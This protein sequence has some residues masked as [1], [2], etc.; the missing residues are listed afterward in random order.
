MGQE[1][2]YCGT[3]QTRLMGSDFEK[4]RAFRA[5][6]RVLCASCA[7]EV[8]TPEE[9]QRARARPEAPRP[10]PEPR[11]VGSTS[12]LRPL[13]AKPPRP[14]RPRAALLIGLGGSIAL[15]LAGLLAVLSGSR[16]TERISAPVAGAREPPPPPV[17]APPAPIPPRLDPPPPPPK[18]PDPVEELAEI[19]RQIEAFRARR[20]F[21][22][23]LDLVE[24]AQKRHRDPAWE[25]AIDQRRDQLRDERR[26]EADR[27]LERARAARRTGQEDEVAR[28]RGQLQALGVPEVLRELEASPA[29]PA[30]MPPAPV[31]EGALLVYGDALAAGWRD[32]SWDMTTDLAASS[33]VFEGARSIAAAPQKLAAGLYLGRPEGLDPAPYTHLSFRL[34]SRVSGAPLTVTVYQKNPTGRTVELHKLPGG[35]PADRWLAYSIP[36]KDLLASS[37]PVTGI[38]LQAFHVSRESIFFVDHILFLREPETPVAAAPSPGLETYRARRSEAALRAA[39]RD[40]A[41]AEKILREALEATPREARAEA[42][43]DFAALKAASEFLEE[44]LRRAARLGRGEKVAV[45]FAGPGGLRRRREGTVVH[46]DTARVSLQTPEGRVDVPLA[47]ATAGWLADLAPQH[48]GAGIVCFLEGDTQRARTLLKAL[49]PAG[50]LPGPTP[51]EEQEAREAFWRAESLFAGPRRRAEAVEAYRKVLSEYGATAISLR[52]KAFIAWRLEEAR[53]IFWTADELTAS[54]AFLAVRPQGRDDYVWWSERPGAEGAYL[55]F[56]FPAWPEAAPRAWIQAGGCCLETLSFCLQATELTGPKPGQPSQKVSL[57]PGASDAL[58]VRLPPTSLRRYHASHGGGA[59]EPTR[60]IWVPLPLP[61][62][63]SA[64]TKRVR[65]IPDQAGFS[66]AGAWVSSTRAAPPREA[67]VAA[68]IQA[69]PPLPAPAPTGRLLR[70]T[71]TGLSGERLEDLIHHASFILNRPSSRDHL[72]GAFA[73]SGRGENYGTRLRGYLHPPATGS[74]VFWIRSDDASE[75]WLSPD[76][77]PAHKTRI[78]FTPQAVGEGEWE[79]H[80]SQKSAPVLLKAGQ[81]CYAEALY[82]Q[83]P[84]PGHLAVGW[85]LPDGTQERPLPANRVSEFGAMPVRKYPSR[86]YRAI[87][88][89]GSPVVI[90]GH[91]WEAG[92]SPTVRA[93]RERFENPNV[94]L[95]PPTDEARARMIRCSVFDPSGTAVHI[96]SLPAGTYEV[97]LY[98]WEDNDPQTIDLFVQGQPVLRGYATGPAGTWARLGPWRAEVRDGTLE[99]SCKGGHG[100]FSGLEIWQAGP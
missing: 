54:E 57:E 74:Y 45:E 68:W 95:R 30:A 42:E 47:E 52:L 63:S 58:E 66:V 82:K 10:V 7:R 39:G 43:A 28:L 61:K 22:F 29:P 18:R 49:P 5:G 79:K 32:F 16:K 83:G 33:P 9:I 90:D 35:L 50:L 100:N 86:L 71:W 97:Y 85:Q 59:R 31:P 76:D 78:A 44:A 19:D 6:P 12:R 60:W 87:N 70:D 81:R 88:L 11:S 46:A 77:N 13:P 92:D 3:C 73:E 65:I 2:V 27:L 62:F 51:K 84:G 96:S 8:L 36:L 1:I 40:Y 37:D 34:Y 15:G 93:S 67:E 75:L 55:E 41:G 21:G 20:E 99:V 23:A 25:K 24:A 64:G 48:P 69:R 72:Y 94:P 56:E 17:E 89:G 38:V 53:D 98:V 91:P 14:N 80:S 4:G 26:R